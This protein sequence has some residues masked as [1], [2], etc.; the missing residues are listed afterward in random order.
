LQRR[1]FYS[2]LALEVE[3][4]DE[5]LSER[6]EVDKFPPVIEQAVRNIRTQ[7]CCDDV[8]QRKNALPSMIGAVCYF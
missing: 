2:A 1:G 5:H 6:I 7:G 3:G 8:A 4:H